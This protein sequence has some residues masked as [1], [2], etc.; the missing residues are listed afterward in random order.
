MNFARYVQH[1]VRTRKIGRQDREGGGLQSGR[2]IAVSHCSTSALANL[3]QQSIA[4]VMPVAVVD[5]LE[6]I[7]IKDD[8]CAGPADTTCM[9]HRLGGP[10][11][12]QAA[13]RKP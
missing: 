8:Q 2:G 6:A 12:E 11:A 1:V 13:V 7:D 4:S 3:P 9:G 5:P 10:V